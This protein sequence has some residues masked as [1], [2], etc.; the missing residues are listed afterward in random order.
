VVDAADLGLV[1]RRRVAHR[2]LEIWRE[3]ALRFNG[4]LF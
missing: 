4:G 2:L 1:P 3:E